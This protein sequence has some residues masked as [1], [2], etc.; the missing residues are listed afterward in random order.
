MARVMRGR[1]GFAA[2]QR[3]K[4]TW[5]TATATHSAISTAGVMDDLLSDYRSA[6]GSTQGCTVIRT[7]IDI[8]IQT[9]APNIADGVFCGLIVAND[10]SDANDFG[11]TEGFLDWALYRHLYVMG[12]T[13]GSSSQETRYVIDLKA[14][15]KVQELQ[16]TWFLNLTALLGVNTT[17]VVYTA[18]TLLALP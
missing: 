3:R 13:S 10:P 14:K 1:R 7:H 9:A 6:G 17:N 2:S 8:A 5:A 4:L 16:E 11:P 15:R 12:T 18:R